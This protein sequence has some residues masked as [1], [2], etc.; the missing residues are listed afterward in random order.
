MYRDA[1]SNKQ[2]WAPKHT[3]F[4]RGNIKE[5]ARVLN[6]AKQPTAGLEPGL[7][8]TDP[9]ARTMAVDLYAGIGYFTFSYAASQ[10]IRGPSF[11]GNSIRGALKVLFAAHALTNG[12]LSRF[13]T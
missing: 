12:S 4:S 11:A 13:K 3:M 8:N 7:E 6:L 9:E 2:T 10:R 5:K 1:E